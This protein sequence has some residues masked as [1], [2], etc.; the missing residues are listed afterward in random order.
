M[1]DKDIAGIIFLALFAIGAVL[2]FIITVIIPLAVF[3]L[4]FFGVVLVICLIRD[5]FFR[6]DWDDDYWS[7]W[8]LVPLGISF[9]VFC[10]AILV[11]YG[12]GGTAIGQAS[13]QT[14]TAVSDAEQQVSGSLNEAINQV[15]EESCKTLPS[16]SCASLKTYVKTAR[17]LQEVQDFASTLKT[18]AKTIKKVD[19]YLNK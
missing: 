16:E 6:D 1:E 10:L 12:I 9:L 7:I 13:I 18:T 2:Y 11:G 3:F 19:N 17:T 8:A 14:Y 4:I 5:L 15:V